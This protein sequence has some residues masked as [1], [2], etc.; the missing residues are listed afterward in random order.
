M[1]LSPRANRSYIAQ[2]ARDVVSFAQQVEERSAEGS[3]KQLRRACVRCMGALNEVFESIE[4]L[5]ELEGGEWSV[6]SG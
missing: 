5:E 4:Q 1:P 2:K 6:S 3:V